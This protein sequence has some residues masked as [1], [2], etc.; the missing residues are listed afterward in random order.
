MT[1]YDCDSGWE[2]HENTVLARRFTLGVYSIYPHDITTAELVA[3][4][5]ERHH[6]QRRTKCG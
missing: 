3:A 5:C 6:H 1:G 4:E 2:S